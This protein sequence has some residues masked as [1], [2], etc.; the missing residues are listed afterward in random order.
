VTNKTDI[1]EE[2]YILL[3]S[4][5]AHVQDA[6]ESMPLVIFHIGADNLDVAS[7]VTLDFYDSI[8]K[9]LDAIEKA[10]TLCKVLKKQKGE[11]Q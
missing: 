4:I 3:R 9:A 8:F 11:K 5:R 1:V 2:I 7:A 6:A 10:E